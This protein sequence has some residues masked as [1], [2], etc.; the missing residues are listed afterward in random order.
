MTI[1][2][3]EDLRSIWMGERWLGL[4]IPWLSSLVTVTGEWKEPLGMVSK[5][6]HIQSCLESSTTSAIAN[7]R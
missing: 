4:G 7:G 2:G 6:L 1:W 5:R 3:W